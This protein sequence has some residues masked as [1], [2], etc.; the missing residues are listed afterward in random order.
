MAELL[1]YATAME[2]LDNDAE[3]YSAVGQAY[4]ESTPG[5][6]DEMRLAITSGD[7]VTYQRHAHSIK[8]SSRTVGGMR[9]GDVAERIEKSCPPQ[10][11]EA[12]TAMLSDLSSELEALLKA[13]AEVV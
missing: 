6:L 5:L 9:L 7:W 8:S 3:I 13:L 1:D 12:A 4:I 2:Y 10:N 11:P